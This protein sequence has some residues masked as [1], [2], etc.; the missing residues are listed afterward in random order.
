MYLFGYDFNKNTH[1]NNH[2]YG[3]IGFFFWIST[4]ISVTAEKWSYTS[5]LFFTPVR[6]IIVLYNQ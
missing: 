6:Q 4:L 5:Y 3:I 1:Q 2:L